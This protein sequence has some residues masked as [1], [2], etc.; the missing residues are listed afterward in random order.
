MPRGKRDGHGHQVDCKINH[1]CLIKKFKSS[2]HWICTI[3]TPPSLLHVT[4]L[5]L[6]EDVE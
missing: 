1:S 4:Y 3:V 6:G 5:S 2:H